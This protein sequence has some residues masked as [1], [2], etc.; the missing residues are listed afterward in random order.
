MSVRTI[1]LLLGHHWRRHRLV[2]LPMVGAFGLF[3]FLIT[4]VAPAPNEVSW[5]TQLM[6]SVPPPLLALAGE[7]AGAVTT[8]GMIAMG[9]GHPFPLLL[10][11]AC[12]IRLSSGALAGEIGRGT[13]DLIAS[14][15]IARWHQIAAA[16]I[17]CALGLAALAVA[18]WMGTAIGVSTRELGVQPSQLVSVAASAWLLFATWAAIG[19]LVSALVRD[20]GVAI[21]W[22]SGIIAGSFVLE[23]LA[24]LWKPMTSFRRLSLFAYYTPQHIVSTGSKP[25]DVAVLVAV[26]CV[27]LIAALIVFRRRDL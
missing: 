22:M 1:A 11:S 4:R 13:M 6:A 20:G 25:G 18:A 8:I 7:G 15:P 27:A 9:Y 23:Y 24:R 26:M 16:M 10:L 2:L 17:A 14:R 12:A 19:V 3:E 5:M 21:G